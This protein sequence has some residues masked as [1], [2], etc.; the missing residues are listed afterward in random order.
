MRPSRCRRS[1]GWTRSAEQGRAV[2]R[3]FARAT[4]RW[5]S[6]SGLNGEADRQV[7]YDLRDSDKSE[8]I[9]VFVVDHAKPEISGES[10]I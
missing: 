6:S 1:S 2:F 8:G 5:L 10:S 9:Y 3:N 7:I 4:E